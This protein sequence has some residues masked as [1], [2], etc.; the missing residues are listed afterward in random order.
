MSE[1]ERKRQRIYDLLDAETN[2]KKRFPK[3]LEFFYGLD[4][5]QALTPLITL[6]G[7]S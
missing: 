4:Q 2:K 5:A 7:V 1:Q 6:Y 3:Y